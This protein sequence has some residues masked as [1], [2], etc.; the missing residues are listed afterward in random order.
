MPLKSK[1]VDVGVFCLSLMG[2]EIASY[3]VEANRI[4]RKGY[5]AALR[6][7]HSFLISLLTLA[8][9]MNKSVASRFTSP[10]VNKALKYRYSSSHLSNLYLCVFV[11]LP[12]LLNMGFTS[13]YQLGCAEQ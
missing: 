6:I 8:V 10:C 4:L 2:T 1:S 9:D 5:V 12:F 13:V 3:I 11:C 7:F